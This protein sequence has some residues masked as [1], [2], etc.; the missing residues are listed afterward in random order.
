MANVN[1]QNFVPLDLRVAP[2]GTNTT[3]RSDVNTVT[4]EKTFQFLKGDT[5]NNAES[6][7]YMG[8]FM[9]AA[10]RLRRV[11]ESGTVSNAEQLATSTD[12]GVVRLATSGEVTT[13]TATDRGVTPASLGPKSGINGFASLDGSALVPAT[14]LPTASSG[15][16]TTGT[17]SV[18]VVTPASLGPKGGANGFASLDGSALIPLSQIPSSIQNGMKYQGT[19]DANGGSAPTGSPAQGDVYKVTVA[20]SYNLDG[21]TD[22]KVGD[23]AVYNGT[24]W[25]KWDN[26]EQVTDVAGKTGSIT[27]VMADITDAYTGGDLHLPT[28]TTPVMYVIDSTSRVGINKAV[29][30]AELHVTANGSDDLINLD[31][32]SENTFKVDTNGQVFRA[33]D[34]SCEDLTRDTTGTVQPASQTTLR[35]LTLGADGTYFVQVSVV[36]DDGTN[37]WVVDSVYHLNLASS[38]Y[39]E[40]LARQSNI[41]PSGRFNVTTTAGGMLFRWNGDGSS[42]V[43]YMLSIRAFGPAG[44]VTFA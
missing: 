15:D 16:V 41:N 39:T 8:L 35:T 26:T 33:A 42:T 36:A 21:E 10:G 38:T 9:N 29:P 34:H 28:T 14:E 23:T 17:S 4:A 25:D 30:T 24:T 1:N 44:T 32:S 31:T 11:D 37:K 27:L 6:S 5:P 7:S 2:D 12:I 13:G 20:G 18:K 22:W 40:T 19:W 43:K 3:F